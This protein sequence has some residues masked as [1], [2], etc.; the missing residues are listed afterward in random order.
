VAALTLGALGAAGLVEW[1]V[2][3]AIGGSALVVHQLSSRSDGQPSAAPA[4]QRAASGSARKSAPR[5]ATPRKAAAQKARPRKAST[6]R[7]SRTRTS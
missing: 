1:P 6:S 4:T 7:R 2:L 5:K 3:L